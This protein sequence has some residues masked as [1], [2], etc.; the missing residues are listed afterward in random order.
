MCYAPIRIKNNRKFYRPLV[1]QLYITVPCGKCR[2]CVTNARHD[3]FVRLYYEWKHFKS[4]GGCTFFLTLTF[5]DIDLPKYQVSEDDSKLVSDWWQFV[6]ENN[7]LDSSVYQ[8][9]ERYEDYWQTA[10]VSTPDDFNVELAQL[11]GFNKKDVQNFFKSLRQYLSKYK[12]GEI[13]YYLVCEYGEQFHRPHYHLLLF[14]PYQIQ[15]DVLLEY[16][17]LSWCRKVNAL[18][19]PQYIRAHALDVKKNSYKRFSSLG[20]K[21]NDWI[22]KRNNN[23]S[24]FYFHLRG[25]C[26]YAK[27]KNNPNVQRPLV[28]SVSSIEYVTKYFHKFDSYLNKDVYRQFYDYYKILRASLL[29]YNQNR[30]INISLPPYRAEEKLRKVIQSFGDFFPFTLN[31]NGIGVNLLQKISGMPHDSKMQ[32]L[33]KES[34]PIVI[35]GGTHHYKV[36]SYILNRLFYYN[37]NNPCYDTPLRKVTSL[38]IECIKLRYDLKIKNFVRSIESVDKI[39]IPILQTKEKEQFQSAFN[40]TIDEYLQRYRTLMFGI[41]YKQLAMYAICFKDVSCGELRSTYKDFSLDDF[42]TLSQDLFDYKVDTNN[43]IIESLL[44]VNSNARANTFNTL[45]VFYGLDLII[46]AHNYIRNIVNTHANQYDESKDKR[47]EQ[48]KE[49]FNMLHYSYV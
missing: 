4:L 26:N 32:Y 46:E 18:D 1:D 20:T 9:I 8:R 19:V 15:P 21:W 5:N 13:K 38:G 48:I 16:V 37:E 31:S 6:S 33:A 35:D 34:A 29:Y 2:E 42:V 14:V 25:F 44:V 41:S 49:A 43:D 40:L 39:Y 11:H 22:I 17:E 3:W 12:D 23:N 10:Y 27:D 24:V 36:P 7:A 30:K 47:N 28:D 45:P